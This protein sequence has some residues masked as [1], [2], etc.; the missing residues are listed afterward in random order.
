MEKQTEKI[1]KFSKVIYILLRI[2]FVVFIVIASLELLAWILT[3][4]EVQPIFKLGSV[5]V[6]LPVLEFSDNVAGFPFVKDILAQMGV[7]EEIIRTI[8]VIVVVAIAMRLFG[9]LKD[10]GT[11]FRKDV[12]KHL[13][14][15]AITLLVLGGV[16]GVVGFL[17]A[18]I[19]WVLY[20]IFDYGC[21][22]QNESD[23]TL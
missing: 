16:T 23:T 5:E 15:L 12:V 18:G 9:T 19:V 8:F 13:K 1:K 20:L 14:R 17:A 6:H 11:P 2:A 10:N 4:A 21:I 22:L 3:L 7:L